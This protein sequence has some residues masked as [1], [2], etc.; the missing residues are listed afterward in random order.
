M[1]YLTKQVEHQQQSADY[2]NQ[3]GMPLDQEKAAD[4]DQKLDFYSSSQNVPPQNGNRSPDVAALGIASTRHIINQE[5]RRLANLQ[6]DN[7]D[8][9]LDDEYG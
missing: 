8:I 2:I 5:Q 1:Q 9:D 3:E 6:M 4:S 7:P